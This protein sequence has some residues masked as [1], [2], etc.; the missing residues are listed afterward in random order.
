MISKEVSGMPGDQQ[1]ANR[2]ML[3]LYTNCP[4]N[5]TADI[6]GIADMLNVTDGSDGLTQYL[7]GHCGEQDQAD[8]GWSRC[9][10]T[11]QCVQSAAA[12]KQGSALMAGQSFMPQTSKCRWIGRTRSTG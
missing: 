2:F 7:V 8:H 6:W 10:V 5:K 3:R 4:R 12:L 1:H 9:F 11:H